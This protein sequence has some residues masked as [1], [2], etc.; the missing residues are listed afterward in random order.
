[1]KSIKRILA[2]ALVLVMAFTTAFGTISVSA[3]TVNCSASLI[4]VDDDF[5]SATKGKTV[6]A[7][8]AGTTYTGKLGTTAFATLQEAYAAV[9]DQ[10][11][12]YVAAG[13]Y[14]GNVEISKAV[15]FYGNQMGVNPNNATDVSKKNPARAVTGK[16][17]SILQ[18]TMFYYKTVAAG[19]NYGNSVVTVNGFAFAG[20]GGILLQNERFANARINIS[21]NVFDLVNENAYANLGLTADSFSAISL[22]YHESASLIAT[23]SVIAYNRIE[24]VTHTGSGLAATNGV[25]TAWAGAVTLERNYIANVTGDAFAISHLQNDTAVKDNYIYN[26][27][28]SRVYNN[29]TR[30]VEVSGNTFDT[31]GGTTAN[32]QYAFALYADASTG[33][34]STVWRTDTSAALVVGNTFKN[35]GKAIQLYGRQRDHLGPINGSPVGAQFYDNLFYPTYTTDC[36]FIEYLYSDGVY[37]PPVYNNYT[38][39]NNPKDICVTDKGDAS[40]TFDFG[41][42]WLNEDMTDSSELLK[43]TAITNDAGVSFSKADIQI[44]PRCTISVSVP[45][46]VESMKLGLE[47]GDGAYAEFFLDED[48]TVP[49]PNNTITFTTG[50]N[51]AYAKVYYGNYSVIYTLILTKK[52]SYTD[53]LDADEYIV[54]PEFGKYPNNQV[55]YVEVEGEWYRAVIGNSAYSDLAVTLANAK[56][57]DTIHLLPGVYSGSMVINKGVKIKGAKAG[58]NPTDMSDPQFG[59]S[60]E[61]SNPAEESIFTDEITFVSGING[62]SIDGIYMTD[63]A[64]FIYSGMF[65]VKGME[66]KNVLTDS[67]A[68]DSLMYRGRDDTGAS[69]HSDFLMYQ[70]RI[71]NSKQ[72]FVFRLPNV[73]NGLFERNVFYKNKG[74]IYMGGTDGSPQDVMEFRDNIFYQS[75]NADKLFYIGQEPDYASGSNVGAG[76]LNTIKLDGNRFIDCTS[77]YTMTLKRWKSGCKLEVVNNRFEGSTKGGFLVEIEPGYSTQSIEI[78]DNYFG[79]SVKTVLTHNIESTANCSHNY[80]GAGLSAQSFVGATLSAPYYT[81]SAMTKLS[82]DYQVT[83]V[84]APAGAIVDQNALTINYVSDTPH[85]TY[86]FE[87]AVSENASYQIYADAAC[88]I[89]CENNEVAMTGKYTVAYVKVLAADGV[90]GVVYTLTIEQPTNIGTDLLG[91]DMDGATLMDQGEGKF[92]AVL[93]NTYVKGPIVPIIS[94]GASVYVYDEADT[95]LK[96]PIRHSANM[97]HPFGKTTYIIKVVSENGENSALYTVDFKRNKSD[98][99]ELLNVADS[100]TDIVIDGTIVTATFGNEVESLIPSLTVSD[101]AT[102]AFYE[103]IGGNISKYDAIKLNVG[104]NKAYVKVTAEDGVTETIYTLILNR[105]DKASGKSILK[106]SFPE[107]A[108]SQAELDADAEGLLIGLKRIDPVAKKVYL[109][110]NQLLDKITDTIVV[111]EGASYEIFTDYKDGEPVGAALSSNAEKKDIK[112]KEG[113]NTFIVRVTASNGTMALYTMTIYN[114]V[115]NT[116]NAL[117]KVNDFTCN[118]SGNV[119]TAVADSDIQQINIFISDKATAKVYADQKMTREI[120]TTMM[121]Y[122]ITETQETF[123][124][125][126]LDAVPTQGYVKMYIKVTSQSGVSA[127]YVLELTNGAYEQTFVDINKHW[128][129]SYIEQAY[130]MGITNG[131]QNADGTY[132]FNPQD[133]ATREQVAIFICNLLGVD[134]SAY[135]KVKLPYK[136]ASKV[137]SWAK[138]AV[139]AVTALKIMGGDGT[140]FNPKANISRQEFM[141]VIGR[142]CVLDTSKGTAKHLSA[143]KDKAKI[144]KWAKAHVQT[145]VAYGLVDGDDKGYINPNAPITRAEIVKIMVCAKDYARR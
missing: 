129:K 56:N 73:A 18:D 82:G 76:V 63:K 100:K 66:W 93:P 84:N 96:N 114:H 99:C 68:A 72:Y 137:S 134:A 128:A 116:E 106:D 102:Y 55:V 43:V 144:A 41:N 6:S 30:I 67:E 61:R 75:A 15:N 19:E 126:R 57:G 20:D 70:C 132:S 52:V 35:V 29:I 64:H 108:F 119:M 83:A 120:A 101:G 142:A 17:E 51:Y 42:Y 8:V 9:Q 133:N 53:Y 10:G 38:Q 81:D 23:E 79:P 54:G 121:D 87:L 86:T 91:L 105:E 98:A 16:N 3:A 113:A 109:Y 88:T 34:Y 1:M 62:L 95:E 141:T 117:I 131:S 71:E 21:Y 50:V 37:A 14:P 40:A 7:V 33:N 145:C 26:A 111:S 140:N 92:V 135:K 49:M 127:N 138:S 104:E 90:S 58:I 27:K 97:E 2:L 47:V 46:P 36:T 103:D 31:V 74:C 4:V 65:Q 94:A 125:C 78:H 22:G 39:G 110:P 5:A 24:R 60:P 118:I 13:I 89:P 85:E 143:F 44:A 115:R 123:T 32:G 48:C 107:Y 122:T 139:S 12:I 25:V 59:R 28:S 69:T 80:Y 136:D 112:L 130:R 45:A 11:S 124:N 77:T